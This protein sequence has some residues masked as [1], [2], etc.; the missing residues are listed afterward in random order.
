MATG[1]M[2]NDQDVPLPVVGL[3]GEGVRV[4]SARYAAGLVGV[5]EVQIEIPE[6][7]PSSN[8]VTVNVLTFNGDQR[9]DSNTSRLPIQ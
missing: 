6:T 2:G 7:S 4:V 9:V 1:Q 3:N 8:D 5:Y